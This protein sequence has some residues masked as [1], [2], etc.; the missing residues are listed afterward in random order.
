VTRETSA[1]EGHARQAARECIASDVQPARL[2]RREAAEQVAGGGARAHV[3]DQI[4]QVGGAWVG[5]HL[6]RVGGEA[7]ERPRAGEE[8]KALARQV[9]EH[10][11]QRRLVEVLDAAGGDAHTARADP[12]DAGPALLQLGDQR[13]RLRGQCFGEVDP[14]ERR[15]RGVAGRAPLRLDLRRGQRQR[16]V[17]VGVGGVAVEEAVHGSEGARSIGHRCGSK[18]LPARAS[19]ISCAASVPKVP[20]R[21]RRSSAR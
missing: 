4:G 6:R 2:P 17:R 13:L 12:L 11:R 21:G 10:Q 1:I 9:G 16:H 20:R 19:A 18:S 14:A 8:A 5:M 3:V 15:R 7:G